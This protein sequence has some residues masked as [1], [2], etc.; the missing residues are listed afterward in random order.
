MKMA[1]S[2]E[3]LSSEGE[4]ELIYT[5]SF[6]EDADLHGT[7]YARYCQICRHFWIQYVALK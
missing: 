7:D 4:D 2:E 5:R 1:E 3:S 6:N